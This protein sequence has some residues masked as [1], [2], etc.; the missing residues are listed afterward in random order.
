ML[1]RK[2]ALMLAAVLLLAAAVPA[3]AY[4]TKTA[5]LHYSGIT[6]KLDGVFVTPRDV[7]GAAVDPFIIDGTTYLPIRAVAS[8]L[9]LT[10]DW[11]QATQTIRLTSGGEAKPEADSGA[12]RTSTGLY[13]A[14]AVLKYPG[15]SIYLDGEKIE[16]KDVTGKVVDPFV[17]DGT[18][19]LPIRAVASALGLTV[20]WDGAAKTVLLY[21]DAGQTDAPKPSDPQPEPA[22]DTSLLGRL[23]DGVYTNGRF[24]LRF[25]VP[26]GW[27]PA[28]ADTLAEAAE[29][30]EED[31]SVSFVL[32][33]ASLLDSVTLMVGTLEHPEEYPADTTEF[34]EAI[35]K[36][37]MA[38]EFDYSF[39]GM[40][41][42]NENVK[43]DVSVGTFAGQ[44][45]GIIRIEIPI[46][47]GESDLDITLCAEVVLIR[48]GNDLLALSMMAGTA[49]DMD[50]LVSAFEP[51]G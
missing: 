42:F 44:A 38:T 45:A 8:A 21:T 9:G 31:G 18:T 33:D 25:T 43:A 1:R 34:Y 16:P 27:T 4:E 41:A 12:P 24:G 29:M 17:I 2:I 35:L 36:E 22:A 32:A 26:E 11:E 49:G 19:Y 13:T 48:K 3:L 39:G 7:T 23:A 15:I 40:Q 20:D 50:A 30:L 51:L 6:I 10:V 37:F 28:D 47:F 14:E 46:A 5:T